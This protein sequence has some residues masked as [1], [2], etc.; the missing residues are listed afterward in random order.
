[1]ITRMI[2]PASPP[3]PPVALDLVLVGAP[4]SGK[5]TQ[6]LAL[7]KELLLPHI[8][9]GDLFRENLKQQT[10]LG[11]LARAYMDRGEL[12]PDDVTDAMVEERLSRADTRDG[13]IMD[14]FPRTLHQAEALREILEGQHRH[15]AGVIHLQVPDQEIVQRLSGRWICRQCQ[16]PYHLQFKP[17]RKPGVC[18][19]CGGI[20]YQRDDDKAETVAA[21]LKTF[22]AQTKP[23]IQFYH[24]AG[25][26]LEV[27]G[28]GSVTDVTDRTLKAAREIQ[29]RIQAQGVFTRSS[30]VAVV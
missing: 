15:V 19:A 17:P 7:A 24:N 20:L 23:V 12:V 30:E 11:K 3:C 1:V 27:N 13:F 9:T 6:A 16:A 29:Q 28:T 5:G 25:L 10:E 14:G 8:A 22:H 4:G 18:D 2:R 21:R 26:L